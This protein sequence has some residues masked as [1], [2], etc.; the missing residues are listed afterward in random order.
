MPISRDT[1]PTLEQ[2]GITPGSAMLATPEQVA[3]QEA[4]EAEHLAHA[5]AQIDQTLGAWWACRACSLG[6]AFGSSVGLCPACATVAAQLTATRHAA[7]QVNG[8]ARVEL[9]TAYLER[10]ERTA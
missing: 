1:P 6:N 8:H 5:A 9:V 3:E 7:E 2:A 4:A 10:Q